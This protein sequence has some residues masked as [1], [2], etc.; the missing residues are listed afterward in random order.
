MPGGIAGINIYGYDEIAHNSKTKKQA[1][2][3]SSSKTTEIYTHVSNSAI[4]RIRSPLAKINPHHT[5]K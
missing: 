5:G 1:K 4:T 3:C 2:F